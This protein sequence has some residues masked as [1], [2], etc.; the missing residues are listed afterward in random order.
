MSLCLPAC[1]L[2]VN[3]VLSTLLTSGEVAAGKLVLC[4]AAH[5]SSLAQG[6]DGLSL[7]DVRV[8]R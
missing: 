7:T 1:T 2:R 5:S 3:A 8:Y 6:K 4:I